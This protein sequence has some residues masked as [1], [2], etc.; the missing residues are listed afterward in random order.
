MRTNATLRLPTARNLLVV[1]TQGLPGHAFPLA[2]H[3]Q[4]MPGFRALFSNEQ[5]ADLANYLRIT[6]GGQTADVDA[7]LVTSLAGAGP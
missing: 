4:A 7:K 3:M 1:I 6:W 5:I 2:E